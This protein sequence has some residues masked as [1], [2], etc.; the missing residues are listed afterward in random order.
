MPNSNSP[1]F[2]S[3]S[4]SEADAISAGVE[5]SQLQLSQKGDLYWVEQRPNEGGRC[6]ICFELESQSGVHRE[7][8]P[9]HYSVQSKVYEYGGRGWALL[10]DS[11]VFVNASDQQIY[12]QRLS[13]PCDVVQIT[14]HPNTRYIEPIW[15]KTRDRLIAIQEIHAETDVINRIVAIS[16]SDDSVEVLVEGA[17]FY[18][19]PVINPQGSMLAFISW[20]H[21]Q[22]PWTSTQFSYLDLTSSELDG[23]ISIAGHNSEEA[24]SQPYFSEKGELYVVT[25][26]SGWWNIYRCDLDSHDLVPVE[27]ESCDMISAPWQ[28]GL[29]HYAEISSKVV[30]IHH[31]HEGAEV[32]LNGASLVPDFNYFKSLVAV[33]NWVCVVAS[34]N[35]QLVSVVKV[36]TVTSE[37]RVVAGGGSPLNESDCSLARPMSFSKAESACFGYFYPPANA[38]YSVD[39]ALAP[40]VVFLH[41]GPTA[42]TYPVLNMKIQYW[43]QR[44]FS[45]LDLNYRGSSNYGRTYR[46]CLQHQWGV[47]EVEDIQSAIDELVELGL[48]D[49]GAVFVRGNSSGGF[50]AL[51]A[52]YQLDCFAAAASLYGVTDPLVLDGCTHKFES[53]YLHWLIGD[54]VAEESVYR[55]RAPLDN[56]DRINCPVIFFQGEKDRVVLPDQ[57]RAMEKALKGRGIKVEAYYFPDEAHGFRVSDTAEVVLKKELEFYRSEMNMHSTGCGPSFRD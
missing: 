51:S 21:P 28:S 14:N 18:S 11:L 23:S 16:L 10:D 45:V 43:T 1:G 42:A 22:Q 35:N 32:M 53:S 50:S 13:G 48:V 40:L 57:T 26:R 33:G 55:D 19:Y 37:V 6:C 9:P 25:D 29:T 7:I 30:S 39:S 36:N 5:Y 34:A 3:S 27:K 44:G 15:D 49:K 47:V 54:P 17:D 24:L 41:G 52:V 4:L 46:N 2:W 20:N 8:T 12:K 56:V 38:K 31:R